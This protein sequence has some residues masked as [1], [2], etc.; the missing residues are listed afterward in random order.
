MTI[1]IFN[2]S[3]WNSFA[4]RIRIFRE[5]LGWTSG[6][7]SVKVYR[8][9][10]GI[11]YWM[12]VYPEK[13]VALTTPI[14]TGTGVPGTNLEL[15]AGVSFPTIESIWQSDDYIKPQTITYQWQRSLS[16]SGPW[17]NVGSL[18]TSY[19]PYLITSSDNNYYF[20]CVITATNAKDSTSINSFSLQVYD[21]SYTFFYGNEFGLATNGMIY[22]D[23]TNGSFPVSDTISAMGRILSYFHGFFKTYDV[24]YRSDSSTFRI[25][26]RLY[27]AGNNRPS[28]PGLEYEIVFY[29]NSNI[30]DL[31]IINPGNTNDIYT[32]DNLYP[33]FV[34][35]FFTRYKFY[36]IFSYL[37]GIRFRITLDA[38]TSISASS[39][40][41]STA[42][43][44]TQAS[45]TNNVVTLTTAVPHG[46][47][48]GST[49]N[50][51]GL[52][53]VFNG[54]YS[55]SG[56][57][58]STTL[59]YSRTNAN[60]PSQSVSGYIAKPPSGLIDGW[61]YLSNLNDLGVNPPSTMSF[62]AGSGTSSPLISDINGAFTKSNMFYPNFISGVSGTYINSTSATASWSNS[63]SGNS[64]YNANSYRVE[65]KRSDNS[66]TVFGP[67]ITTSTSITVNGLTLGVG[68]NIIVTPNSRSDG[69]GQ[70][71]FAG[72]SSYSHAGVPSIPTNLTA[73]VNSDT[74]ITLTWSEPANNGSTITGYTVQYKK[75]ADS[76]WTTWATNA[77]T[78]RSAPITGLTG[79]TLYNFRVAAVNGIGTGDWANVNATTNA[80]AVPPGA[81][82][83]LVASSPSQA[84]A[85]GLVSWTVSWTPPTNNGGAAITKYQYAIDIDASGTTYTWGAW[86]DV[87]VTNGV[88][89][90]SVTVTVFSGIQLSVKVRAVNS[91]GGGTESTALTLATSPSK[92]GTPSA[93]AITNNNT[94]V[95][96]TST[97]NWT[98]SNI[99]G[100]TSL[101]YRIYRGQNTNN[102]NT[103]RNTSVNGESNTSFSDIIS[104]SGT[105]YYY[106]V[107]AENTLQSSPNVVKGISVSSEISSVLNVT[108]PSVNTPTVAINNTNKGVNVNWSGNA[109][110][111][112][113]PNYSVYRGQ[114]STDVDAVGEGNNRTFA[115]N[116][117][118][119]QSNT[120]LD[121]PVA[122]S[123]TYY[124]RV[125]AVNSI[126][127]VPSGVSLAITTPGVPTANTP[128]RNNANS[129]LTNRVLSVNWSGSG[130]GT[131]RYDVYRSQN[132]T[133]NPNT[134]VSPTGG[135]TE[136]N[137]SFQYASGQ[138]PFFFRVVPSS[139]W[140][141]GATTA[142]STGLR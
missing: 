26:H 68:Y 123:T 67:T 83:N 30:V 71:G 100:G 103:E 4:R 88:P 42:I 33:A 138:G 85:G 59:T 134:L 133:N 66:A 60:I 118:N 121:D 41:P 62:T 34:K 23:R 77:E 1:K 98:A 96:S 44:V 58:T 65:V 52:P 115:K 81:P 132:T 124:Y 84:S 18:L 9:T 27:N 82:T 78:D 136:T 108:Q 119:T 6:T 56:V 3:N 37:A 126:N 48:G 92:P 97:I 141:T 94:N 12:V 130:S 128:T 75:N 114:S 10:G 110:S 15:S 13:P 2:G 47:F 28:I 35:D 86:T 137:F 8:D 57:P 20:R 80:P 21:P 99:N 63:T 46:L 104:G 90:T 55:I 140:G 105:T 107:V 142:W 109:G 135:Q 72:S 106:R 43:S 111:G 125:D 11:P 38:S 120:S 19:Q 25:Y 53:S 101:I 102:V 39:V 51:I 17:S 129:N 22:F 45:L 7:K 16:S 69:L 64:L 116:A 87:A 50:V 113:T 89:D 70:F 117:T 29:N 74:Q 14:V 112:T 122:S 54:A 32:Y 61:I 93:G 127:T 36:N 76:T 31:H 73:T 79:S 95:Q 91:A 5:G 49:I 139:I 40:A 24:W 131:I